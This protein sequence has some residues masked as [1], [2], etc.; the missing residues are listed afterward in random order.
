MDIHSACDYIIWAMR[1]SGATLCVLKLQKLLYY[2]QAWHLALQGEPLF[3]GKFQAWPQGPVNREIYDRFARSGSLHSEL[4]D[5]DVSCDFAVTELPEE[6]RVHLD[7]VLQVYGKY[8]EPELQE[9]LAHEAP[10]QEAN[11]HD[12]ERCEREIDEQH[13]RRYC[14]V[15]Y[16]VGW[17]ENNPNA[18]VGGPV[19]HLPSNPDAASA[20]NWLVR[21]SNSVS[22]GR[23]S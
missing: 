19:F 4:S 12:E 17:H 2:A 3:S 5:G 18:S 13:M 6:K 1:R 7:R 20:D 21:E 8:Q 14:T 15:Q 23:S 10:W 16:L 22:S 11:S 9:M